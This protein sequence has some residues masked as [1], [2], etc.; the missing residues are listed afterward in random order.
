MVSNAKLFFDTLQQEADPFGF[1][2]DIPNRFNT[3]DPFFEEEWLDFKG[4][5]KDDDD[6]KKIWSK[7]L[8]G[9]ANITDGL[10]VW[11]IDAK[12]T[13]PRNIDA[14]RGWRLISDPTIFESKLRKWHDNATNPPVMG[15]EYKSYRGSD[16]R[17]FVVCYIPQSRHKPHRA[18]WSEKQQFYY[19]AGDDFL[20]AGPSL[21][22]V[23]FYP[24]LN[25]QLS[26][27]VTLTYHP[28]NTKALTRF[29]NFPTTEAINDFLNSPSIIQCSVSIYNTGT[30]TAKD[31]HLVMTGTPYSFNGVAKETDWQLRR[32]LAMNGIALGANRPLHP[33]DSSPVFSCSFTD[34]ISHRSYQ[35]ERYLAV[36]PDISETTLTFDIYADNC[37][38]SKLSVV[39][40]SKDFDPKTRSATKKVTPTD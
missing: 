16:G 17:G 6:A 15:V 37:E 31:I 26:L 5:P 13:L 10:I 22:R 25:P 12:N 32:T 8:S 27:E 18:E 40:E 24:Q 7:A 39:F 29:Q 2:F 35:V 38:P 28:Q 30:A 4:E 20:P 14:A 33:G 23:L 21:L 3:P 36:V 1:L 9:Y 11:G 34:T 19:R